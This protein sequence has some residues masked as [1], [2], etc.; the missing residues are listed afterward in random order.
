M[1]EVSQLEGKF[2]VAHITEIQQ[3]YFLCTIPAQTL[4]GSGYHVEVS[5]NYAR[6]KLCA[7]LTCLIQID[8][9]FQLLPYVNAN[10]SISAGH[11]FDNALLVDPGKIDFTVIAA[12]LQGRNDLPPY[13]ASDAKWIK[14]KFRGMEFSLFAKH[15]K[16]PDDIARAVNALFLNRLRAEHFTAGRKAFCQFIHQPIQG[17]VANIVP[18]TWL[19]YTHFKTIDYNVWKEQLM[20]ATGMEVD[21]KFWSIPGV[22]KETC[23]QLLKD[24]DAVKQAKAAV[25]YCSMNHMHQLREHVSTIFLGPELDPQGIIRNPPNYGELALNRGYIPMDPWNE[26]CPMDVQRFFSEML[27]EHI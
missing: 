8:P 27:Q 18:F 12:Y 14:D 19:P 11:P 26:A 5:L 21:V 3:N 22:T 16:D 4:K 9:T 25:L 7:L 23:K 10:Q 15:T 6:D 1:N 24:E 13:P 17:S 20:K 2:S